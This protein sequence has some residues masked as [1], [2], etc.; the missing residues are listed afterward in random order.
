MNSKQF[1]MTS[2]TSPKLKMATKR[3]RIAGEA[4]PN[5]ADPGKSLVK[6]CG[7]L[8]RQHVK[9][10]VR[11]VA[12]QL[13]LLHHDLRA[14]ARILYALRIGQGHGRDALWRGGHAG[15]ERSNAREDHAR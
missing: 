3:G 5:R 4:G 11:H 13:S 8:F 12:V 14:G 2:A 6:G 7:G 10:S 9:R 1:Y 15:A